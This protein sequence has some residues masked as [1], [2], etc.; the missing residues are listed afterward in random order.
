MNAGML[1]SRATREVDTSDSDVALLAM[2]L[3]VDGLALGGIVLNQPLHEVAREFV[4]ALHGLLPSG[5]PLRRVPIGVSADRLIGGVDLAATLQRGRLTAERGV[6]AAAD[7]GIV[8][9]PMAERVAVQVRTTLSEVLDHATVRVLRDGVTETHAARVMAVLLDES[10]EQESIHP[11]LIDRVAFRTTLDPAAVSALHAD[12]TAGSTRDRLRERVRDARSRLQQVSLEDEWVAQLCTTA[13]LFGV[14]SVRALLAALRC[15]RAHAALQGR[16]LV[17]ADDAAVA[18]RLVLAPRATRVPEFA[19]D[20]PPEPPAD[21]ST[22]SE[23]P[24]PPEASADVPPPPPPDGDDR[25]ETPPD[26]EA[27]PPIDSAD[28]LRAAVEAA[29]PP[30]MLA[31]LLSTVAPGTLSGRVGAEH[32]S[33]LRGRPRGARSGVPRG[34]ARVHLL[35]TLRAAAPWQRA[36]QRAAAATSRDAA[37][38]RPRIA[39]AREDMRIRRFIERTGTTI[40]FLVDASGSS[41]LNRLGEAKG[42]IELLLAESYARRDRVSLIAFRGTGTD[43]LLPATRALARARRILAALPGGGGTPMAAAIDAAVQQAI[44][45][46]RAGS[47]PMIVILSDGR[48]N[49]ARDGTPGRAGAER[50]AVAAGRVFAQLR[51]PAL[52]VDTSLRGEPMARRIAEAMR[53]RY[54]LLPAADAKALSGLVRTAVQMADAER[55]GG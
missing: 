1:R 40:T 5:A 19:P 12:V 3:A 55:V 30:G 49:I 15:A 29:L 25:A 42:A 54:V 18:A 45:T 36:R 37:G 16:L 6:L 53:A 35:E 51:V 46:Q 28:I 7:G 13:E 9:V 14:I 31:Q 22:P 47:A 23:P 4:A 52:F 48:A 24:P 20:P 26:A 50:D 11:S 34:G 41:A 33:M 8:V 2:L 10:T 27:M 44:A 43:I 17:G 38:T 32:T 21:E 39:I